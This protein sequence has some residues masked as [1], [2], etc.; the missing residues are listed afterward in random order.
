MYPAPVE[1]VSPPGSKL[2]V[3]SGSLPPEERKAFS[4]NRPPGSWREDLVGLEN[5]VQREADERGPVHFMVDSES[6]WT[7]TTVQLASSMCL[8]IIGRPDERPS[9]V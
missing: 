7:V 5:G 2:F 6:Y 4:Q 1:Q 8:N 3:D 9:S